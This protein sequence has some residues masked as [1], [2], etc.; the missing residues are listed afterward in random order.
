M[1]RS[2]GFQTALLGLVLAFPAG[3]SAQL[4]ADPLTGGTLDAGAAL[5]QKPVEAVYFDKQ[6]NVVDDPKQA[7][8]FA[9]TDNVRGI[10]TLPKPMDQMT[11]E[12]RKQVGLPDGAAKEEKPADKPKDDKPAPKPEPKA[13]AK[14]KADASE[15]DKASAKDPAASKKDAGAA[16]DDP[17]GIATKEIT[18]SLV[19]AA[20]DS[21]GSRD[22]AGLASGPAES[23]SS[24]EGANHQFV[25][26]AVAA[27]VGVL[28]APSA[29]SS[30]GYRSLAALVALRNRLAAQL[31]QAAG[32]GSSASAYGQTYDG[33]SAA[34]A[35]V[36][37]N[38]READIR[39]GVDQESGK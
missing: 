7:A 21:F 27:Q 37:E 12:E 1:T 10:S 15:K 28:S 39:F 30:R 26:P 34:A 24:G 31:S 18:P 32:S 17:A 5:G 14:P 3:A 8:K 25:A 16:K 9:I 23:G 38:N 19:E 20:Q 4:A 29:V 11:A 13:E 6:G 33:S 22:G 36:S 2:K 35:P